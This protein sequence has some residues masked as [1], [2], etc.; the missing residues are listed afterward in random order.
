MF[1]F[2]HLGRINYSQY[3]CFIFV[4]FTYIL[5]QAKNKSSLTRSPFSKDRDGVILMLYAK[6]RF[7]FSIFATV[8]LPFYKSLNMVE[9]VGMYA[10][11]FL[12]AMSISTIFKVNCNLFLCLIILFHSCICFFL[13]LIYVGSVWCSLSLICRG[14]G[15]LIPPLFVFEEIVEA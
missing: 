1:L 11:I 3:L 6:I 10:F 9:V 5:Q 14:R 12:K 4:S 8:N 15:Q 2:L 7:G 13:Q